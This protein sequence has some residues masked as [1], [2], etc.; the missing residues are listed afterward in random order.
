MPDTAIVPYAQAAAVV[1]ADGSVDRWYGVVDVQR[2]GLGTYR[3]TIDPSIDAAK[4]VPIA[5]P[6]VGASG[7]SAPILFL[8]PPNGNIIDVH[9]HSHGSGALNAPFHIVVL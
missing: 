8:Q 6:R 7:Q 3:V 2:T 9:I 1:N 5:T 4:S